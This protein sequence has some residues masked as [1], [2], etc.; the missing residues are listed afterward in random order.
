MFDLTGMTALVTGASGG[1][2]SAIARGLANQGARLALSGSNPE[3]LDAFRGELK[4]DHVALPCNLAEGDA[5]LGLR[6]HRLARGEDARGL[7][8]DADVGALPEPEVT[9]VVDQ[10]G[11]RERVGRQHGEPDHRTPQHKGP[12]RAWQLIV[13]PFHDLPPSAAASLVCSRG[14]LS[15]TLCPSVRCPPNRVNSNSRSREAPE[16]AVGKSVHLLVGISCR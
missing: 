12:K 11:R 8:A 3:K 9:E 14:L 15:E 13:Q 16:G 7:P 5:V 1:I 10:L 6:G 4:G 2:G